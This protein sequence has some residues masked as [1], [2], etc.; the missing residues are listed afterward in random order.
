MEVMTR[1]LTYDSG[2]SQRMTQAA[3]NSDDRI[4]RIEATLIRLE[5]KVDADIERLDQQIEDSR[6]RMDKWEERFIQLSRDNLAITR[7]VIIAAASVVI[8]SPVLQAIPRVFASLFEN[9]TL[10]GQ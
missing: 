4:D 2:C 5:A 6:E 10:A 3:P 1:A 9:M 8:L 7:S